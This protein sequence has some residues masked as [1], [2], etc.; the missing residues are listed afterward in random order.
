M[1][2]DKNHGGARQGAGRKPSDRRGFTVRLAVEEH[3]E[4][5]RRGGS[6]WLRKLLR[7]KHSTHKEN[8]S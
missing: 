4:F 2:N 6:E 7:R 3:E 8:E 5:V 1:A